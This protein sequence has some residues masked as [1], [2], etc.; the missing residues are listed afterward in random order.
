MARSHKPRIVAGLLVG[1]LL[2]APLIAVLYAAWGLI[3]LPFVPYDMFDL[4]A[5]VLPGRVITSGI[6]MMVTVIRTLDIGPTSVV[7][8]AAEHA[9][10][11]GGLF[12]TGVI[13]GGVLF[14]VLRM[15]DV[16]RAYGVGFAL[17]AIFGIAGALISLRVGQTATTPPILSGVWILGVFLLWGMAFAWAYRR[18]AIAGVAGASS[19]ETPAMPASA[20]GSPAEQAAA[21]PV[22]PHDASV[23]RIDRRRFL[24][25]LGGTTAVITVAGAGVGA[26]SRSMRQSDVAPAGQRWS[27]MH[28]LP[29]AGASVNPVSGTRPEFTPLEQHY[30]IDINTAPPM[31]REDQW[32][33]KVEGL[34]ENP[35]EF[36]LEALRRYEPLH[37]FVTLACI[38]NPIAGD[39]TST[40]RWTG[41]SLQ[42]LLPDL[43]LK[44]AATHLKIRSADGFY[45][46]LAL[47]VIRSEPRVM[48][49]YEWDGVP[50]HVDHGFPLRIY[51]PDRYGMKQPKWIESIEAMD[52]SEPGYWVTRGWSREALMRATSVIDAIA[53]DMMVITADQRT[54]IPIGGI[55]H[56]GARGISRVEVRV[57]D[58]PWQEAS[59][60]TP[61]SELTWII[62]RYDWPFQSGEHTF[63][64][65]CYEGNG[66]PQITTRA[67]VRPD[68]ATG[69][70]SRN[71]MF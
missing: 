33:L 65:R 46:I 35:I 63:T 39:L 25:R 60:R 22:S 10:A 27:S 53:V 28:P 44:P 59:L 17:G 32:R 19:T 45:E 67:P 23:E 21:E 47:E 71:E 29:N 54:L 61:L 58:G 40:T 38:S 57:D 62:W 56:A 55:A 50:L 1:A 41:V 6:D 30:R 18:L 52:H 70:H 13:A 20:A 68:G 37:E 42:R 69:L 49:T 4:M 5:R 31:I 66:T 15:V 3:G 16:R 14:G 64:V 11:I 48:L 7:A 26:L 51:I 43:H 34:V 9:L 2:T 24:I 36:S 8:K 12:I